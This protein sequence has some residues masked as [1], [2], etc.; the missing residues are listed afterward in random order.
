MAN[1]IRK[2]WRL[3]YDD[4]GT[5]KNLDIAATDEELK[6]L[7]KAIKKV[8]QDIEN[9]SFNTCVSTFMICVNDL[10]KLKTVSKSTLQNVLKLIAPF[11]PHT[12]DVLWTNLGNTNSVVDADFPTHD[13]KYL[14]ESTF[15]YPIQ[16]N[17]KHRTNIELPLDMEN[18]EIQ[19]VVM[20]NETVQK[21][22]ENK[23]P[24]KFIVVKGRIVNVVV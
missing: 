7:H 13:E 6:I 20:A 15:T 2:F 8:N 12:A 10:S 19:K 3:F 4:L 9:L 1:F 17:G 11:A 18:D 14:T 21:F 24:K 16:I 23:E 5:P 22:T